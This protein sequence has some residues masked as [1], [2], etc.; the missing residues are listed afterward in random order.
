[1]DHAALAREF[2]TPFYAFDLE[3]ALGSF[4]SFDDAWRRRFPRFALAWSYKTNP[5]R[6]VTRAFAERGAWA[7]VVSG[8]EL[9]WALEDG[10]PGGRIVFNGPLKED[11]ALRRAFGADAL[12]HLDSGEEAARA[13]AAAGSAR[14]RVGLRVRARAPG[15][16]PMHFGVEVEDVP[17]AVE[18]VLARRRLRLASFHQHVGTGVADPE[19]Y[20]EAWA[21]VVPTL[22]KLLPN[23]EEPPILDVG[24]GYA[25]AHP[26]E[27]S[28]P[29]PDPGRYADALAEALAPLTA[30]GARVVAEPGRCLVEPH[31]ALVTRVVAVKRVDG[32][33]VLV[34]DGGAA[35]APTARFHP[36]PVRFEADP[37]AREAR[38][39]L[40]GPLC[41]AGDRVAEGAWGPARVRVGDVVVVGGAGAYDLTGGFP[42]SRPHAPVVLRSRAGTSLVRP[43]ASASLWRPPASS[44]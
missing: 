5:L 10:H 9:G 19:A 14:A 29:V 34:L 4:D 16:A 43:S 8:E 12:V 23:M 24:G 33:G 31:G 42:W 1:M 35:L 21:R 37:A 25:A 20:R 15:L 11:P 18:D 28:V 26:F 13:D 36:H 6:M 39:D 22:E 27:G 17:L 40:H 30:R 7:D 44:P 38:W 3:G 41:M 32:R 2:E